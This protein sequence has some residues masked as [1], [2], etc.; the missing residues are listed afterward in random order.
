MKLCKKCKELK[1]ESHFYKC[2]T[3]RDG[4]RGSCV[5]CFQSY[6]QDNKNTQNKAMAKWR[7]RNIDKLKGYEEKRRIKDRDKV[8]ARRDVSNA[9]RYG[10]LQKQKCWCGE[11]KVEAHHE[12]YSKTLEVV[13]LCE[14]HHTELELASR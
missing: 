2:S 6:H 13:W 14:K 4:L 7:L 1:D 5:S 11:T 8:K 3:T 9:L 12:D 10:K